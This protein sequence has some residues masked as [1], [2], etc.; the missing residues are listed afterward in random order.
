MDPIDLAERAVLP[1]RLIRVGM[2]RLLAR[3][4]RQEAGLFDRRRQTA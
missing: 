3:R 2:R 4:L 1:D